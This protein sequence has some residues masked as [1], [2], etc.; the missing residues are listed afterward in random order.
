M[1]NTQLAT[2]SQQSKTSALALMASRFSVEPDK[3]LGTLKATVFKGASNEELLALVVVSNAYG[4][5]PLTKEIYAFPAKGGGIVPIVSV[6]GWINMMNS[7]PQFDGIDFEWQ[8]DTSG[9]VVACTAVIYRK[10]RGR[11]VRVTEF[12]SECRRNTDP[13]KMVNRM[14]RHKALIQGV[15]VAFGF[16]GIYDEEEGEVV[17]GGNAKTVIARVVAPPAPAKARALPP[18]D[19]IEIPIETESATP[20][21]EP[22]FETDSAAREEPAPVVIPDDPAE[23]LALAKDTLATADIDDKDALRCLKSL[24]KCGAACKAIGDVSL[25]SLVWI[26]EN[27][28]EVIAWVGNNPE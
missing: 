17:A 28:G 25:G 10:D 22:P 7:H 2:A 15:R 20:V 26:V 18:S 5:N 27:P 4:L 24:K 16:S 8:Y 12:V 14:I 19:P 11:P 6:D 21:E 13:W 1:S 9:I 3:L 23:L